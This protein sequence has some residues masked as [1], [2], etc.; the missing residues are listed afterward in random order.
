MLMAIAAVRDPQKGDLET[1]IN[2][3]PLVKWFISNLPAYRAGLN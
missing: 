2:S 1:P 3:A